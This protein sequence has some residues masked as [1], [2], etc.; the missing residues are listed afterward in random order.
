MMG[1]SKYV[2]FINVNCLIDVHSV[3]LSGAH[4]QPIM[5]SNRRPAGQLDGLSN[6]AAIV[7]ADR[8][9][10]AAVAELGRWRYNDNL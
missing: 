1:L 4:V 2:L 6:L 5:A 8:A 3:T 9:F 7:A 10:P